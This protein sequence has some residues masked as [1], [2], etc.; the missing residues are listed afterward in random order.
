MSV[1]N[2]C[3]QVRLVPGEAPKYETDPTACDADVSK[4]ILHALTKGGGKT[5]IRMRED[6][7]K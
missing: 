7:E 1:G 6:A 4:A 2:A 5:S 3:F